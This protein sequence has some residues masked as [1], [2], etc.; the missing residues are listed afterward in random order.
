MQKRKKI[1]CM[2][3]MFLAG[4][5]FTFIIIIV[6][7]WNSNKLGGEEL[8]LEYG[9]SFIDVPIIDWNGKRVDVS[10]ERFEYIFVY[11][12]D[13]SCST[14]IESLEVINH[15]CKV[16][17][18]MNISNMIIWDG[19]MGSKQIQKYGIPNN[20]NYSLENAHISASTPAFYILD[21]D[22]NIIFQVKDMKDMLAKICL[23]DV[24]K[25]EIVNEKYISPMFEGSKEDKPIL[26][27]FAMVGCPDCELVNPIIHSSD[28]QNSF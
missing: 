5:F 20:I 24:S 3:L 6:I 13:K 22:L 12:L 28:I 9:D 4:C 2:T 18:K 21:K 17:E 11:Y 26:V 16:Y 23:L 1:V 19:E 25:E 27:Y 15:I 10:K 7:L 14:C 8:V